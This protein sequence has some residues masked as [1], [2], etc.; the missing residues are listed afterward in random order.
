MA[1][2]SLVLLVVLSSLLSAAVAFAVA[3]LVIK[4]GPA[5]IRGQ[6]GITGRQ[7][8]QGPEGNTDVSTDDVVSAIQDDPSSVADALSGNLDYGDIQQNLDPD[9]ADVE[10]DISD[11]T[12][13]VDG[14]CSDLSSAPA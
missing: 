13:K 1:A 11:L 8:P 6:T 14:L 2:R 9:P 12:D 7:G 5:G 4:R 3:D 10:Q